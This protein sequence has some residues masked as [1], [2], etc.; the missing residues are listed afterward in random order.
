MGTALRVVLR[1]PSADWDASRVLQPLK[2]EE[3][4]ALDKET[5]QEEAVLAAI[6]RNP[7]AT[8]RE[9]SDEIGI[10]FTGARSVTNSGVKPRR[11]GRGYKPRKPG[12]DFI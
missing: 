11:S 5:T 6:R 10:N 7:K 2:G 1:R 3:P 12:A 9:L 4:S 8:L